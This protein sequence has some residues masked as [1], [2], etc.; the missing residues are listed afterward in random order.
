ML[1]VGIRALSSFHIPNL[2]FPNKHELTPGRTKREL[3]FGDL[4]HLLLP[5]HEQKIIIEQ[6]NSNSIEIDFFFTSAVTWKTFHSLL[7]LSS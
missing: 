2:V 7:R 1:G 6:S 5:T 3:P 4:F